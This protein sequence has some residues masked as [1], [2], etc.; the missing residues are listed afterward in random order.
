MSGG[1]FEVVAYT[2]EAAGGA[3]SGGSYSAHV[4]LAQVDAHAALEGGAYA[5]EGGFW[6]GGKGAGDTVFKDGFE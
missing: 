1:D 4:S 6:P 2:V 3:V 5:L